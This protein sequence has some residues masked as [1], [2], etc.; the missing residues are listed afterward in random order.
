MNEWRREIIQEN[1][2]IRGNS[3]NWKA[4]DGS[5]VDSYWSYEVQRGYVAWE[6]WYQGGDV[7]ITV[8]SLF[9]VHNPEKTVWREQGIITATGVQAN[10]LYYE[11]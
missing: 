10:Y 7:R 9:R 6:L 11:E 8:N 5:G 4:D 1:M 2:T 3:E